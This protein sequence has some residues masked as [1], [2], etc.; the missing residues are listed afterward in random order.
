MTESGNSETEIF[1]HEILSYTAWRLH[2][3]GTPALI[4]AA[5]TAGEMKHRL[6][7]QSEL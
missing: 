3:E 2:M 4:V 1:V 7:A 6:S 5:P